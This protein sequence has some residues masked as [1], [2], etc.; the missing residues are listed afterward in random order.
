[1]CSPLG[2]SSAVCY[3]PW[4]SECRVIYGNNAITYLHAFGDS[5]FPRPL[6]AT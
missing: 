6:P 3:L 5:R 4:P 2:L 1:M